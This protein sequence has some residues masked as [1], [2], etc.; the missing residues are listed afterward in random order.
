MFSLSDYN[1]DYFVD[2]PAAL[3]R[4]REWADAEQVEKRVLSVVAPPGGGKTWVLKRLHSEWQNPGKR[5]VVWIDVPTLVNR[6]EEQDRN[7]MINPGAFHQCFEKAL[8]YAQHRYP[9]IP[10]ISQNVDFAAMVGRLAKLLCDS[11][12]DKAPLV[13]VD[14]YDEIT[15]RQ[16]EVVSLHI[17][18]RIIEQPCI[19]LLI[20]HRAEWTVR[21]DSIRRN[22]DRLFLQ[23]LDPLSESF[24]LH[25]F[26]ML[27]QNKY[28]D[29]PLLDPNPWMKQFKLYK[30]NHP[31]INHFLFEHGLVAGS[32]QF[33]QLT[34]QE[35]YECTRTMIERP[36]NGGNPRYSPLTIDEF[37]LLHRIAT[38][39]TEEWAKAE[40]ETM[41][42]LNFHLDERIEKL[43][44]LGLIVN[45][46]DGSFYHVVDGLRDLLCE[47]DIS[48]V[49]FI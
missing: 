4:I 25:Q 11:N 2:R 24:A 14:G 15:K 16:A 22:Q 19:R 35:L 28:P 42:N 36:D 21:G 18:E 32:S 13:I 20:A 41:L 48:Q 47:I 38:Q 43:F 33:R 3:K 39:I 6:A 31:L 8:A 40:I 29:I 30:W 37:Q 10:P 45:I 1:P 44:D 34:N 46:S 5:F 17:L 12:L 7:R 26:K 27:F 9:Q 49:K 23:K